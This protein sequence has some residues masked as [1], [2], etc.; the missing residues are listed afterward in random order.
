MCSSPEIVNA[1]PETLNVELI[2]LKVSV[3]SQEGTGED[4]TAM[5]GALVAPVTEI[6]ATPKP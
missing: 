1:D 5:G 4:A 3:P 2:S 6:A